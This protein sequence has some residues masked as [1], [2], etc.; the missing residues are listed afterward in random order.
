MSYLKH[1]KKTAM[2][3]D[4]RWIVK[5]HPKSDKIREVKQIFNPEEYKRTK[6]ARELYN[7][8][9]LIKILEDDKKK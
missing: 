9:E 5:T 1:L 6:N 3:L 4:T 2:D 7:K 8:D